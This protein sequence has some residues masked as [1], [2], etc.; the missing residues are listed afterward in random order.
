[1]TSQIAATVIKTT[2]RQRQLFMMTGER[3]ESAGGI[4]MT[5]PPAGDFSQTSNNKNSNN[6]SSPTTM[7]AGQTPRPRRAL[8]ETI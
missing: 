2:G 8:R 4:Y 5:S 1:M 6:L 7:S 3:G